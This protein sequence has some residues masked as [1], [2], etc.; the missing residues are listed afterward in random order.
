MTMV[1][2]MDVFEIGDVYI[3]FPFE[4]AKFRFNKATHKVYLRFYGEG[5]DEVP[6][7]HELFREAI[8]SGMQI[9]REDYYSD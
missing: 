4:R 6:W 2:K 9:T 1:V 8:L 7:S 3:D 5:E